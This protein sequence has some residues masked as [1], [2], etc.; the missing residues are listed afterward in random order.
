MYH[1]SYVFEE[2]VKSKADYYSR[3]GWGGGC[4]NGAKWAEKEWKNLSNPLRVHLI[5]HPPSWIVPFE[6]EHPAVVQ[7]MVQECGYNENPAILDFLARKWRKYAKAGD[8]ICDICVRQKSKRI[9]KYQA[10]MLVLKQL[11]LP[12][13]GQTFSANMAITKAALKIIGTK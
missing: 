7:K 10:A 5:D 2:G 9:K 1:Y 11:M 6:G 12:T 13:D 4:D 8:Y 3:M